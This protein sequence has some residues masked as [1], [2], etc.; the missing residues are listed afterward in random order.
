ML[1]TGYTKEDLSQRRKR[2]LKV[3]HPDQKG[4]ED[5]AKKSIWHTISS[6]HM[7]NRKKAF[8][9][10]IIDSVRYAIVIL[11][12]ICLSQFIVTHVIM[13]AYIP[14]AS[15]EPG[16]EEGDYIIGN[17][18]VKRYHRGDIAIFWSEDNTYYIKRVIGIGGDHIVIKNHAVYRNGK[19]LKEPY[20]KEKN[21][22]RNRIG[23]HSSQKLLFLLGG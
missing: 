3:F 12:F 16:L 6:K 9:S 19:K 20:I 10:I 2:L 14:S 4:E 18:M 22:H 11:I 17:R 15:M 13:N 23:I 21:A 8:I 5:C 1:Q 7:Q